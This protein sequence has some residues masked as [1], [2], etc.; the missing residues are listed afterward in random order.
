MVN[1]HGRCL[2]VDGHGGYSSVER[3]GLAKA[4]QSSPTKPI[5]HP[6]KVAGGVPATFR[7]SSSSRAKLRHRRLPAAASLP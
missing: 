3:A 7:Q 2:L 6:Q 1:G 5:K 4:A